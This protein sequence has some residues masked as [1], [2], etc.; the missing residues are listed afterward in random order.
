MT[1]LEDLE[2]MLKRH[3][4]YSEYSDDY[5]SWKAGW[6]DSLRIKAMINELS[7]R[8]MGEQAQALYDKYKPVTA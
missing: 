1:T 5:R 8:G 4:W 6:E 7:E 2:V 3:D